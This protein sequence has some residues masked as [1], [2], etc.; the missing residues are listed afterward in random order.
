MDNARDFAARLLDLLRREQGAMADFLVA[1]AAFDDRRLWM[2]LGHAS[3]FAFLHRELGLSKGASH[4]RKVAAELIQRFPEVV[5][6]LR[7]GRLCITSIVELAKVMTPENR[8][9]VLPRFFHAS[10]QEAKAVAAEICPQ[11]A[12]PQRVVVTAQPS[13]ASR[14]LAALS[15]ASLLRQTVA[16]VRPVELALA[17]PAAPEPAPPRTLAEPLTADLR[18]LHVTVSKRFLEKLEVAR[19]ALSHSHPGADAEA[20]LEAGLDLLVERAARR[21]GIVGSPRK[22]KHALS[23]A[24]APANTGARESFIPAAVKREVWIR[25]E[26]RC[27]WPIDGGG[28]CGSTLRLEYDHIVPRALGG[29]SSVG[30]LRLCCRLHN[31]LAARRAFGDELMDRFARNPRSAEAA[32][33]ATTLSSSPR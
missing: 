16:E 22:P 26:G 12:V 25:D 32:A 17:A 20:I 10:K 18:R 15:P 9:E 7:D 28:V 23:P 27:Q 13:A 30:N 21:K 1:L 8:A 6:P 33:A 19:V 2:Q 3:L 31:Q 29:D 5:P 11:E 24:L 4:F 14:P